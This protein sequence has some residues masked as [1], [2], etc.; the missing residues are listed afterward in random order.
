[1]VDQGFLELVRLDELA[2]SDPLVK[3]SLAVTSAALGAATPS[4]TGILRYNGDG[5]GTARSRST[6]SAVFAPG[7]FRLNGLTV[8]NSG[9]TVTFQVGIANLHPAGVV[10]QGLTVP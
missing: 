1:M 5:T 6:G 8:I 7:S 9:S 10:L 2:A 3:N 4:G